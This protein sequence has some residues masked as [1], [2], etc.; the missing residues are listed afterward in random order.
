MWMLRCDAA[1]GDHTQVMRAQRRALATACRVHP[2]FEFIE[3]Y[4]FKL[5]PGSCPVLVL[6]K[7]HENGSLLPPF[8]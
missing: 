6:A 8:L 2:L 3:H 7:I 1:G 5:N 4:Y